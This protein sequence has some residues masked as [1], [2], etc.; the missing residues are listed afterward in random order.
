MTAQVQE[1]GPSPDR[2]IINEEGVE[3]RIPLLGWRQSD[4]LFVTVITVLGFIFGLDHGVLWVVTTGGCLVGSVLIVYAKPKSL[5]IYEAGKISV[6]Y[7]LKPRIIRSASKSSD[8]DVRNE[9]GL[10]DKTPFKPEERSQDLTNTHL[11]FPGESAI[12]SED[13]RMERMI[14][15]H[16]DSMDFAPSEVW[17]ARQEIGQELANRVDADRFKI[18]LTTRSFSFGEIVDRLEGRL[19]DPDIKSSPAARSLLEDYYEKRPKRMEEQN[20]QEPHFYL[21]I[22]V[23]KT[24]VSIGYTD[25]PTPA[26]KLS[27][28]PIV[29][30]VVDRVVETSDQEE[31]TPVSKKEEMHKKMIDKLDELTRQVEDNYIVATDGY[32][33]TRLSSIEMT[34]LLAQLNN[35]P[36]V[37]EAHVEQ[38]FE[39]QMDADMSDTKQREVI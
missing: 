1:G 26:E 28:V 8:P 10:L 9:G 11:I 3:N 4:A 32:T 30:R 18:Y 36:D 13:G 31:Q 39:E 6:E 22:S 38:V 25:E 19:D 23:A 14:E 33:Y 37:S 24:D 35:N 16:G 17:A 2:G 5:N 15:I 29:G 7:L 34:L 12:L 21:L 20:L 27:N